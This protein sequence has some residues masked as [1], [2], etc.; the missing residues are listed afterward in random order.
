M[1]NKSLTISQLI[2]K[3]ATAS[4]DVIDNA[5]TDYYV[6]DW[7]TICGY[8]TTANAPTAPKGMQCINTTIIAATTCSANTATFCTGLQISDKNVCPG[9][10]GGPIYYTGSTPPLVIG[11]ASYAPLAVRNAPCTDGH[12]VEYSQLAAFTVW[13]DSV[14]HPAPPTYKK[15]EEIKL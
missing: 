4:L 6:S 13:I 3:I 12:V 7:G 14:L 15:A 2:E 5:A 9:D 8:G 10:Y 11:I 1:S